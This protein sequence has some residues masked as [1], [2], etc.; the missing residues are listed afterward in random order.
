[1]ITRY[2]SA[3]VRRIRWRIELQRTAWTVVLAMDVDDPQIR[4]EAADALGDQPTMWV[5][6]SATLGPTFPD[7]WIVQ[8]L[9]PDNLPADV[10]HTVMRWALGTMRVT[11]L[12]DLRDLDS[13]KPVN[14]AAIR[15][16]WAAATAPPPIPRDPLLQ[17]I[18]R[19]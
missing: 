5:T 15:L 19:L 3:I 7:T 9:D 4:A 18:K 10:V 16:A 14:S 12:V 11:K 8:R 17:R 1:M 2:S 13:D 6:T